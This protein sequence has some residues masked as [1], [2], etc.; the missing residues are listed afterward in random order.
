MLRES[1][2]SA[3][4]RYCETPSS[5]ITN[6]KAVRHGSC[7]PIFSTHFARRPELIRAEDNSALQ[8]PRVITPRPLTFEQRKVRKY[9]G[10]RLMQ[11]RET[12]TNA[13]HFFRVTRTC[14]SGRSGNRYLFQSESP[15]GIA[16]R[17]IRV[18]RSQNLLI[19]FNHRFDCRRQTD[20]RLHPGSRR[21]GSAF[22]ELASER[23][24]ITAVLADARFC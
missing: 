14:A 2:T 7:R 1:G 4:R 12:R 9:T 16:S 8:H 24:L 17:L 13:G 11:A 15:R 5:S 21:P 20:V 10:I 18:R 22:S 19:K 23:R 6:S 3:S